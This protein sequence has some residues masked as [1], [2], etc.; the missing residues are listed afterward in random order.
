MTAPVRV[1]QRPEPGPQLGR[2]DVRLLPGGEVV[3]FV[4]LARRRDAS[5]EVVQLLVLYLEVE[6]PDLGCAF[7]GAA[8]LLGGPGACLLG[9]VRPSRFDRCVAPGDSLG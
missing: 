8:L 4:D 5:A 2:E 3:A 7:D 1:S 9:S 6:E